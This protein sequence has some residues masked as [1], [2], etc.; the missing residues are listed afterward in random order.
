[1][2]ETYRELF[3]TGFPTNY[4]QLSDPV[5]DDLADKVLTEMD[6]DKRLQ[7]SHDYQ[8][9]MVETV[10]QVPLYVPDLVIAYNKGLVVAD[11]YDDPGVLF[12]G[13]GNHFWARAYVEK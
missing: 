9:Y 11:N 3:Y 6:Q 5:V 7:Y 1:M 13:G 2:D 4:A 10:Y 12:A 8:N